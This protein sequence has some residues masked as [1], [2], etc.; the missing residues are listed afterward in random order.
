MGA[1][2]AAHFANAGV[3]AILLDVDSTAVKR[4][5]DSAVKSKA[6][7]DSAAQALVT[8]GGFDDLSTC[9]WILEAVTE[10]L[11][12][13]RDLLSR[14]TCKPGTIV[15]TNTSG[16]PLSAIAGGFDPE[17]R[18]HFF[19]AHF[20]NPPRYL[21]LVELIR[22]AHT[23]PEVADFVKDFTQR[24]LGKGVVEC[25]DTPNFIGNRIGSFV[26]SLV[27][28]LTVEGDYTIEEVDFLTG[29]LIGLPKS[30]SYRLLDIVGLD[31]WALV[32][33]NLGESEMTPFLAELVNRG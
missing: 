19:G 25:K 21:H 28:Q 8:P 6:F 23:L 11:Q 32:T 16:I 10:N 17:F 12:V 27:Q 24:R 29:P 2:I 9:D 30:A 4:G 33:K 20:F 1:R 18:Q 7:Y 26:G 3:P 14:I 22:G 15:S 31:V 5:I 13:K